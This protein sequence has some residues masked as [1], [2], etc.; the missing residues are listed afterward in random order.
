MAVD[1]D[2]LRTHDDNGNY[3]RKKRLKTKKRLLKNMKHLDFI[4]R[5]ISAD[6]QRHAKE[7]EDWM[8]Q[9]MPTLPELPRW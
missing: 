2:G 8:K 6:E 9:A 7:L 3:I 5:K 4:L 1:Q